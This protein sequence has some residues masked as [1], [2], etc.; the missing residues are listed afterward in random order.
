M[1][2]EAPVK[3]LGNVLKCFLAFIQEVPAEEHIYFSKVDLANGYWRMIVEERSR[4]NF[5]YVLPGLPGAP[6]RLVIPSALQMGW[7]ESPAY[8]CAATETARDVAQH[9]IDGDKALPAHPMEPD[10]EPTSLARCQMSYND[11]RYQMSSVYVDN[12]LLA[13]VENKA[14]NLLEKAAWATLRVIHSVF[15]PPTADDARGPKIQF[16]KRN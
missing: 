9:W 13:A 12:F 1:A 4:W 8:F 10:T 5:A 11:E 16:R 15:P 7:N 6:T 14:G 2:P 3:E